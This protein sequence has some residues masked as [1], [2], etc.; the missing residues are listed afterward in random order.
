MLKEWFSVFSFT[1]VRLL[2]V[3]AE[4]INVQLYIYIIFYVICCWLFDSWYFCCSTHIAD[5]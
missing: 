3:L 4:N 5:H 2:K 1:I